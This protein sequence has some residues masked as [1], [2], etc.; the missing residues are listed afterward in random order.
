MSDVSQPARPRSR[1]AF[2][3][4]GV[5]GV[6]AL[7]VGGGWAAGRLLKAS[8]SEP[9]PPTPVATSKRGELLFQ[10]NCGTC[11]GPDGRGDGLTS[12]TLKPPPRDFSARPW[13][14][15]V[16]K[17]SI[18]RVI[19]QGIPGTAMPALRMLP[20][21]DVDLLVEHVYTLATSRPT[22]TYVPTPEEMLLRE[23]GFIDRRGLDLPALK[24]TDVQAKEIELS[25]LKGQLVLLHFWGTAC[26]HCL[27]EMPAWKK[28]ET[29]LADRPFTV[30][31]ICTDLDD[32]KE[33]QEILDPLAPGVKAYVDASGLSMARFEV[34]VL[35]TVW[36]I[37][38]NGKAIGISHGAS[39][40]DRRKVVEHWLN[41]Q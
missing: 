25:S 28:L 31:H 2:F 33:A 38:A 36:M 22:I 27:K 41:E 37:D 16:S 12:A 4:V 7:A 40:G 5:V 3:V 18:R 14:Y 1:V 9:S 23:A 21:A 11:H 32:A 17:E 6:V 10:M 8:K 34:Q 39:S 24:L 19:T 30:L 13:R 26:E 15:E 35:P 20:P 29:D